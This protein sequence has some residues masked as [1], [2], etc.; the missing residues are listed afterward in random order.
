MT[1]RNIVVLLEHSDASV[2]M[3]LP[4]MTQNANIVF[5]NGTDLLSFEF[6]PNAE[7]FP[8]Q[9]NFD[10]PQTVTPPEIGNGTYWVLTWLD[11]INNSIKHLFVIGANQYAPTTLSVF[12]PTSLKR[13]YIHNGVGS[14]AVKSLFV[15]LFVCLVR[16]SIFGWVELVVFLRL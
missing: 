1:D 10:P 14:S 9:V 7:P 16:P 6:F 15:C 8:V 5:Y 4:N 11:A 13:F 2:F 12:A 3:I